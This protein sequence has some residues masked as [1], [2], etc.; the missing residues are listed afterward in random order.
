MATATAELT[1]QHIRQLLARF[2]IPKFIVC[3]SP[4]SFRDVS[5]VLSS[6][7]SE[8]HSRVAKYYPSSNGLAERALHIFKTSTGSVGDHLAHFLFQY[9]MTP[10]TTTGVSSA[11]MLLGRRC[12]LKLYLVKLSFHQRVEEEQ[13]YLD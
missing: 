7:Q 12:Y 1:T 5:S 9:R 11:E 3:W 10:H 13:R 8:V 2:G 4:V 6:Q